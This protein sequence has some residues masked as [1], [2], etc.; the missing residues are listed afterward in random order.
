[1]DLRRIELPGYYWRHYSSGNLYEIIHPKKSFT[2]RKEGT[3]IVDWLLFF[4]GED[5]SVE[6]ET[7][8]A[9]HYKINDMRQHEPIATLPDEEKRMIFKGIFHKLI[10]K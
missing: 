6:V 1:M 2:L 3:Y 10:I 4:S 5:N 7:G 8:K 9:Y